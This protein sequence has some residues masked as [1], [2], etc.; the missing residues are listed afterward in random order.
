MEN[1]EISCPIGKY[2]KGLRDQPERRWMD[3]AGEDR[4]LRSHHIKSGGREC[5]KNV[6]GAD[7]PGT[8]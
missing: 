4:V 2:M 1:N 5:L 7:Y 8:V 6:L 3:R